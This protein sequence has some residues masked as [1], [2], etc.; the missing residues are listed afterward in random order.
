[1]VGIMSGKQNGERAFRRI[2]EQGSQ[3]PGSGPAT[4]VTFAAPIFPLP[5]SRTSRLRK[6]SASTIKPKGN[7]SKQV[8]HDQQTRAKGVN[9]KA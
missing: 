9:Q 3:V 5:T 4:R 1:M 6:Q 2:K 8:S 7:R